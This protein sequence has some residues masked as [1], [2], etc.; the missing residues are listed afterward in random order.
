MAPAQSTGPVGI[1]VKQLSGR[2]CT[3]KDLP[4]AVEKTLSSGIK[5]LFMPRCVRFLS[6]WR[7][8]D[9]PWRDSASF[10]LLCIGSFDALWDY[11]GAAGLWSLMSFWVCAGFAV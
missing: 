5:L 8:A 9:R 3:G 6:D 4:G 11:Y 1:I 7:I 10:S 2:I